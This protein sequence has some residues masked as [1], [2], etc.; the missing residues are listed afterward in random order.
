[1][2]THLALGIPTFSQLTK[3]AYGTESESLLPMTVGALH[4]MTV[5]ILLLYNTV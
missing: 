1:M 5:G 2:S 4:T 3:E